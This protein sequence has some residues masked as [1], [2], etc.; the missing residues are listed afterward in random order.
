VRRVELPVA[1][2][3]FA[4]RAA[5]LLAARPLEHNTLATV[6]RQAGDAPGALR[7]LVLDGDG[8]VV[9]A[10][11]RTP[12]MPLLVSRLD[13]GAARA[14][15]AALATAEAELPGVVGPEPGAGLVARAWA[16]RAGGTASL[17][18]RQGLYALER[19]TGPARRAPGRM[20]PAEAGERDLLVAWAA[21][22]ASEAGAVGEG[23]EVAVDRRLRGGRLV[24]WEDGGRPVALAGTS[25]RIGDVVRVS[26]V[27]TP[28]PLRRRGY[29]GS[30][31]AALSRR[32]LEAGATRC[33]LY[34]DLANPTSNRVYR[35]VGYAQV[36]ESGLYALAR[37]RAAWT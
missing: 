30:L 20:R 31:V 35:E 26:L 18:M 8:E 24:V 2:A 19:V 3:A 7:A 11:L 27:Y 12:P 21:A 28:P 33:L 6:L 15:A 37:E 9:G 23:P 10:A 1:P 36:G 22:F 29:A 32:E 4:Q 16:A 25:P 5:G 17:A 34:T 14:L 13:A